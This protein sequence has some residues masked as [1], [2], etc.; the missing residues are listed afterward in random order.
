MNVAELL[1]QLHALDIRLAPDGQRLR[2]NAP[3]GTLTANLR[4]QISQRKEEILQFLENASA[5]SRFVPPPIRPLSRDQPIPLSFA[6][7]R[8]W[9]LEQ[10]EPGSSVYSIGRAARVKGQLS[11]KALESSLTEIVRRHEALRTSFQLVDGHAFQV[12]R[13]AQKLSISLIELSSLSDAERDSD[14]SLLIREEARRPFDLSKGL[15]LRATLLRRSDDDH[16]LIITTH[17][18]VSDAW[19]MGI[20]TRELWILYETYANEN[21]SPFPELPVQYA[22][23]AVW[24]R[25]WLQGAVLESQLAYWKKQLE[26]IP[27]VNLP[28]DRPRPA[29]QSFRGAREPIAL[30]ESLTAAIN[31]LSRRE[32][33]TQF[34][35]LLAAFNVLLYRYSGQDDVVVGSP[36]TNRNRTEI[37]GVIGFFVNTL[38][39]RNNLAGKPTFKQLLSR[40]RDAFLDAYAHQDLPFENLVQELQADRELSRNPLFQVMFA[41]QN[42][43]RPPP[44]ISRITIE[45]MEIESETSQFDLS[46]FLRE[47][48]GKL[49][50]FF[51]YSTE[52]FDP[53]KIKRMAGHF[54]T[55]L[56]AIVTDPGQTISDLPMLTEAERH[57]LLVK[58][59]DTKADYP[60]DSCIHELFEAQVERTPDAVAVELE[61]RQ[62]SY[63]ELNVR[64]N[65]LAHYLMSLSIGPEKL[66]G[67]CTDRSIEMVIGLLGILKAGGAYVPLDPAY[68]QA[69]LEFVLQDSRCSVLLTQEKGRGDQ[70]AFTDS[71]ASHLELKIV[72]LDRDAN[73]ITAEDGENPR[74]C[75]SSSNLAY[76]IYTS[77]S[78]G[79]PKGVAIEHR[80]TVALLN[81]AKE[82]FTASELAGVLASTSICFDLSVFELFVPLSW[83]GRVVLAENTLHLYETANAKRVTLINTVPSLMTALLRAGRLPESVRVVNLAGEPLRPELVEELYKTATVEKVYDLYGPSETTTYSTFKL[84]TTDSP[85]T[86]GRPI[87]NTQVYIL[88][89]NLK[90]VPIGVTGEIHIGGKGV[91]RGYLG[92]NELTKEKFINNPF[93]DDPNSRLYRTGDLARYLPDGQI[94][95]HGRV[96]NQVKIR[97]YRIELGE[98]ESVL[99]QHPA[100]KDSLVVVREDTTTLGL[101]YPKSK[102]DNESLSGIKDTNPEERLV[103]YIVASQQLVPA[104]SELRSFLAEKLPAH[105]IPAA[106]VP[107]DEFPLNDNGKLDRSKLPAPNELNRYLDDFVIAP[108][109]ELQELIANV[110]RN[111]LKLDNINVHDNFFELGGHSLLAIQILARLREALDR[112][113]SLRTLFDAPT[114]AGLAEKLV[115]IIRD[116]NTPELPPIVPV[117]RER[118]LPLSM[119][120]E[121]LWHLDQMMPGMHFFNMPYV[122]QLSGNLNIEALDRAV[123]EIVRRHEALRT[124]FGEVDGQ[125]VQI[126]KDGE[127]ARLEFVDLRNRAVGDRAEQ[128]AK[129]ILKEREQPFD[130]AKGPLFRTK[131]LRLSNEDHL[132]LVTIHHIIGDHWSIEVLRRELGLL[133]SAF[134]QGR[135]SPLSEPPMQFADYAC[136]ERSL[137]DKSA[138]NRELDYWKKQLAGPLPQVEF[139]KKNKPETRS[140]WTSRLPFDLDETLFTCIK[141]LAEKE[142]CTPFMVVLTALNIVLCLY[143]GQQNIRIG[144]LVA[145]RGRREIEQTIGH[146]LNTLILCTQVSPN[147]THSQLLRQVRHGTIAAHVYQ[148]LPFEQLARILEREQK[149][150]RSSLCEV[151]LSYQSRGVEPDQAAGLSFAPFSIEETGAGEKL[152]PTTF[153][154]IFN[155]RESSTKLTGTVTYRDDTFDSNAIV[156]LTKC[157]RSLLE[158]IVINKD[159][160]IPQNFNVV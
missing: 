43:T 84:R 100:V 78:T 5:V 117:P 98:I 110:W 81:W 56:R 145:N 61:G 153:E 55:L 118:P 52:L 66:V 24:Q 39:L 21:P 1:S 47:R 97:G 85:A 14:T 69:R 15:F 107:L 135:S 13:P 151:L 144:M 148:Q 150:L 68:P 44:Q 101:E 34:M 50:G 9:F 111:V 113:V 125:A 64:A 36:V 137:L 71:Q 91:G 102:F 112:E 116:G 92:R 59:N 80:N 95:C 49:I 75:L 74:R 28:M 37:E 18:I 46:L 158:N 27:I 86:I 124:V 12:M 60:K 108:R 35:T 63:R 103:A 126:I 10:L 130:I 128:A 8:L 129:L 119:N 93:S 73:A 41:L 38:V 156:S 140:F 77:G 89:S 79:T 99:N 54:E 121:H 143:S 157:F 2:V 90:P 127:D 141:R 142:N 67:I 26:N 4:E 53:P 155:L 33:V 70:L 160:L 152:M 32:A 120:Q 136:W 76:V 31:E 11:V 147:M 3:Q 115:K 123:R 23:Y 62:V 48:D 40:V 104:I 149:I 109:T 20:L 146:F 105:M 138:L 58:W 19:S 139:Q 159:G 72:A 132:F 82:V 114:I 65:Q 133:Y 17:H 42:A 154:L 30:S 29:K 106:I 25:E 45:R 6:Q 57:Q 134:S 88:D 83:G 7:E 96:D 94:Q 122:Y 87:S 16:V 22:D 51:D 131:L